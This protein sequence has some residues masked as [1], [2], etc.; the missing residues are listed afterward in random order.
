MTKEP[1]KTIYVIE[2]LVKLLRSEAIS[3]G[4]TQK[5]A[6]ALEGKWIRL[7]ET[8]FAF[9][10]ADK[11]TLVFRDGD[12]IGCACKAFS[13]PTM[14]VLCEHL[15][16]F[17]NLKSM[18]RLTIESTDYRWL[19]ECLFK[20]GWYADGGYI[21][22]SADSQLLDPVN[23]DKD[24]DI[25]AD[26]GPAVGEPP[27]SA[28]HDEE[29][30][31]M[32]E[33][34]CDWCGHVER[35]EDR[36]QVIAAIADHRE[37]CPKNPAK[38]K[39][40]PLA[41]HDAPEE[42]QQKPAAKE[43]VAPEKTKEKKKVKPS[44]AVTK[45]EPNVPAVKKEM[46]TEAEFQLAKVERLMK[47]QGSIYKVSG[48]EVADSAAV[49]SYAVSSGVSTETTVLEQTAEYARATVRAYKG[50]RYTEGSVLIRRD[51]ILEKLMIDLAEKNP[52]W[53][54]GWSNGLPEFD[55]NQTVFIGDKR[56]ILGL[57][58]AGVVIDKWTFASRDCETK[59]GR[60]AQIKI[61]GADWREDDEVE[62]EVEEMNTVAKR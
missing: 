36:D 41:T 31:K 12:E 61:L 55:L 51:A 56:K 9:E 53:I 15:I 3:D 22:P 2:P 29:P 10:E 52:D 30:V 23:K 11:V 59:A 18:P 46:P 5:K 39:K 57:H 4:G 1:K 17:E 28:D 44:T 40:P 37:S 6:E 47:S 21:H 62:S 32:I 25:G 34:T 7:N 33:R 20:F 42:E 43:T 49:S 24:L 27:E 14:N 45:T 13:D 58:I 19:R 26:D 60:R 48:K 54:I 16:A 8:M 50:G 38:R 35:G